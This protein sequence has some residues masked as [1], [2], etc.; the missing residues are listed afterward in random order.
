MD[1]AGL[2]FGILTAL[3]VVVED[4]RY[5]RDAKAFGHDYQ[6]TELKFQLVEARIVRWAIPLGL[7]NLDPPPSKLP[8]TT[9]EKLMPG[10]DRQNA[11]L[12]LQAIIEELRNA[13]KRMSDLDQKERTPKEEPEKGRQ[14]SLSRMFGKPKGAETERPETSEDR[15]PTDTAVGLLTES[16]K[17]I[18]LKR[19]RGTS[20]LKKAKWA[21]FEKDELMELLSSIRNLTDDL[22]A[23]FPATRPQLHSLASEDA[24]AM[25][26]E[27]LRELLQQMAEKAEVRDKLLLDALK[28]TLGGNVESSG[29]SFIFTHGSTNQNYGFQTTKD[30][31]FNGSTINFGG[32]GR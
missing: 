2:A 21:L 18:S 19:H 25:Q 24:E 13:K 29:G 3:N 20:I 7:A 1:A 27:A 28:K 5:I 14:G 16:F 10:T 12:A 32:G 30:A 22:E 9:L 31:T 26:S 6:A 4:I 11:I 17:E 15:E 23:L 8:A